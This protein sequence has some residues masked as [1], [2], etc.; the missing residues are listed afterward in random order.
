MLCARRFPVLPGRPRF[1][2]FSLSLLHSRLFVARLISSSGIYA[3]NARIEIT[4]LE[5]IFLREPTQ[6]ERVGGN[7]PGNKDVFPGQQ[8]FYRC[9]RK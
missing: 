8:A 7:C 9:D 5:L 4:P 6:R 2:S 1:S 3:E